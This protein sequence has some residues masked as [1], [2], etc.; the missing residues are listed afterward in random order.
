[1][2]QR[3]KNPPAMNAG[4]QGSIPGLGRSPGEGNGNS[5]QFSGLE[6]SMDRGAWRARVH[7]VTKSRDTTEGLSLSRGL[8]GCCPSQEDPL[9]FQLASQSIQSPWPAGVSGGLI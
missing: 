9:P 8:T 3:V 4:D 5:L 6:N 2:A 1:M 7:G